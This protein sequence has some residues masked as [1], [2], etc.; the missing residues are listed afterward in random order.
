MLQQFFR[1][2]RRFL[3]EEKMRPAQT[4]LNLKSRGTRNLTEH[5][6]APGNARKIVA[7][8]I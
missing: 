1:E 3:P 5:V 6:H 8:G 4:P 2:V 7:A